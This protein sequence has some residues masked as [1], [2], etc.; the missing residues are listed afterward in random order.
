MGSLRIPAAAVPEH[1]PAGCP[2]IGSSRKGVLFRSS[3]MN[4]TVDWPQWPVAARR[5]S[6]SV[7][8]TR[9][10]GNGELE[11]ERAALRAGVREAELSAMRAD[12]A[13]GDVEP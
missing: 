11:G 3:G 13:A 4:V 1:Q 6:A 12:D 10:D 9:G 7:G 8:G 5:W 2:V